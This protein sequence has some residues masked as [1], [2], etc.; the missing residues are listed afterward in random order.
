MLFE[1]SVVSNKAFI[2]VF[3]DLLYIYISLYVI[4][5]NEPLIAVV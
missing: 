2:E 1:F 3:I 5:I 4:I